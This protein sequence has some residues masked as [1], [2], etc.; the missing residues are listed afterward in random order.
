LLLLVSLPRTEPVVGLLF[1][2]VLRNSSTPGAAAGESNNHQTLCVTD[3]EDVPV[4]R[5][6]K[7]TTQIQL[8]QAVF[9]L[10]QVVGWYRVSSAADDSSSPTPEDLLLSEQLLKH[11]QSSSNG[12]PFLFTLLQVKETNNNNDNN[13][14]EQ[15]PLQIFRVD[16]HQQVLVGVDDDW[17][18]ETAVAERIAVERVMKEQPVN[19]NNHD[20]NNHQQDVPKYVA[21][22]TTVQQSVQA[23]HERLAVVEEYLTAVAAG[24][25]PW[26]A[27]L[28][29]QVQGLLLTTGPIAAA[30]SQSSSSAS[31]STDDLLQQLAVLAKTVSAVQQYT[32]K[33]RAVSDAPSAAA[34]RGRGMMAFKK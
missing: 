3:A 33:V 4:N 1:G 14:D 32:D 15:L 13:E 17:K 25:L 18:L 7:A 22:T 24:T 28:V 34:A 12:I 9:P 19:N 26:D 2:R 23:M 10:H 6:D 11:Y 20:G 29:R 21:A 5:S 30:S 16:A 27:A 8:H 31:A